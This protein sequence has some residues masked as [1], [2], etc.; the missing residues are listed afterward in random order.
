ME[1]LEQKTAREMQ[2]AIEA[3]THSK[4]SW[5]DILKTPFMKYAEAVRGEKVLSELADD[6]KNSYQRGDMIKKWLKEFWY[7]PIILLVVLIWVLKRLR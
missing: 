6:P 3:K 5:W 2:E 1:Y 7:I 4:L